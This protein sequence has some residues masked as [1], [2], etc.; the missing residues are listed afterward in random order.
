MKAVIFIAALLISVSTADAAPSYDGSTPLKCAIQTVTV[1]HDASG[2]V[3]GTAQTINF[4]S[5][6]TVD[7]GN[8]LISDSTIGRAARISSVAHAA[9][10]LMLHGQEVETLGSGFRVV[11]PRACGAGEGQELWPAPARA[12]PVTAAGR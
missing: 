3:R 5:A 9:G 11:R 7:V 10:R 8:R 12:C 4:P 1:C 2:C 6:V